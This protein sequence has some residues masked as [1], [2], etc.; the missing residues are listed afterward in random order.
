MPYSQQK[1]LELIKLGRFSA[2]SGSPE[3]HIETV[4][5]NVFLY[6]NTVYKIYK[7]DNDFFNQNFRDISTRESRFDFTQ[8]D[9]AW[10]NTL[11]PTIY[12][13][14]IG[15]KIID[16][17]VVSCLIEEA[18]EI[19]MVMNRVKS[20]DFLHE[21]LLQGSVSVDD[22]KNIGR[23][24]SVSVARVQTPVIGR[25]YYKDFQKRLS[26]L[27]EW[28]V[29]AKDA[30]SEEELERYCDY[31]ESTL[32]KNKERFEAVYSQQMTKDGDIHSHNAVLTQDG[33][34]LLDTFPPKDEW[35]NGHP[36]IAFYRLGA[37]I[38]VFGKSEEL[39]ESFVAGYQENRP[40][41]SRELES[42]YILYASSI[43]LSYQYHLAEN[44]PRELEGA[45]LYHRFMQEYYETYC[46]LTK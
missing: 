16:N 30:V 27:R 18:N 37:D 35:A 43:M 24:F 10:N 33:F 34:H 2:V 45:K 22:A 6:H 44:D 31:L 14:L 17:A 21:R 36:S 4:I 28:F 7:N 11:S 5:S 38:R 15:I 20:T 42:F 1:L 25:N 8:R 39:F 32:E 23:E 40:D 46:T 41:F 19:A 12:L 29:F 13:K 3:Q 9:F 26:D